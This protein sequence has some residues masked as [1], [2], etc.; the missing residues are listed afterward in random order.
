MKRKLIKLLS[1]SSYRLISDFVNDTQDKRNHAQNQASLLQK[2]NM[3][4]LQKKFAVLQVQDEKDP[5]KF[6]TISGWLP[7]QV[8]Q[9]SVMIRTVDDQ[10]LMLRLGDIKKVTLRTIKDE[11]TRIS[12]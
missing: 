7:A 11:E 4:A 8:K 9:E 10:I 6:E 3:A 5:Q 12:R 2:L 1:K